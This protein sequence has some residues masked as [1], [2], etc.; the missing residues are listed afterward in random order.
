VLALFMAWPSDEFAD[1][2]TAFANP[3]SVSVSGA[4]YIADYAREL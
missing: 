2:D 4:G 1:I 3:R